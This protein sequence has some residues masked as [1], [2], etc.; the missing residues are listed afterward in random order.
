[1]VYY[2]RFLL[3]FAVWQLTHC[4]TPACVL[5]KV[6]EVIFSVG[7]SWHQARYPKSKESSKL[8]T[9]RHSCLATYTLTFFRVSTIVKVIPFFTRLPIKRE[10]LWLLCSLWRRLQYSSQNVSDFSFS[11]LG[12]RW[13]QYTLT[14]LLRLSSSTLVLHINFNIIVSTVFG[15]TLQCVSRCFGLQLLVKLWHRIFC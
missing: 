8:I 11:I 1:M 14:D 12:F 13:I 4:S 15:K 5:I 3:L 9:K 2:P 7:Q 10:W 6:G